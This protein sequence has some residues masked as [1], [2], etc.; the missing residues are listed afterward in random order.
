MREHGQNEQ[1]EHFPFGF[2]PE[3]GGA[4]EA[5]EA[6]GTDEAV[7]ADGGGGGQHPYSRS[8][9]VAGCVI[10]VVAGAVGFAVWLHGAAPGVSGAFEGERDLSLVYG[11][12]PL[13]L[14]GVPALTLAAW[15]LVGTALRH[16]A[17][18]LPG[19][20]TLAAS[21]TAALL[22][23]SLVSWVCLLWLESRVEPFVGQGW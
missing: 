7:E 9:S 6:D 22:A 8:S 17:G 12:L 11:E 21:L 16:R 20:A 23:L 4:A 3:G 13:M 1:K 19:A 10:A 14:F 5:D 15:S 2:R 18:H